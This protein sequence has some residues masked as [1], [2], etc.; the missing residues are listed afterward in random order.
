MAAAEPLGLLLPLCCSDAVDVRV[1]EGEADEGAAADADADGA[2]RSDGR[3]GLSWGAGD[4]AMAMAALIV[5][6]GC[7]GVGRGR[8]GKCV[9]EALGPKSCRRDLGAGAEADG[10]PSFGA[11]WPFAQWRRDS[12][13]LV[14]PP[15][16]CVAL[17]PVG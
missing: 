3:D 13:P 8:A 17:F 9:C 1:A 6:G 15:W 16:R 10:L 11:G 7:D 5:K 12:D 4:G 14:A 2:G